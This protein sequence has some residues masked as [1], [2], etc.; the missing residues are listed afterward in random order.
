MFSPENLS[1]MA[2]SVGLT[3]PLTLTLK[4]LH[5]D[6]QFRLLVYIAIA[7]S[8]LSYALYLSLGYFNDIPRYFLYM[9]PIFLVICLTILYEIFSNRNITIGITLTLPMLLLLWI[10]SIL[11]I[12]KGGVYISYG[13]PRLNWTNIPLM[14]QLVFY[15]IFLLLAC[16]K[17]GV[18]LKINLPIRTHNRLYN[19]SINPQRASFLALIITI[20]AFSIHFSAYS[21]SNSYYFDENTAHI[22]G[23]L[24]QKLDLHNA[25]IFSNFYT[26]MRP[27]IPD[28]LLVENFLFPPPMIEKEFINFLRIAPN[29]TF[30]IISR[31]A[32]IAWYEYANS[33]IKKYFEIN[34]FPTDLK[35]I[36]LAMKAHE[37]RIYELSNSIQLHTGIRNKVGIESVKIC[38]TN[39]TNVRLTI[40]AYSD[41]PQK[42]FILIGT[43]RFSKI[44]VTELRPGMNELSW[45]FQYRLEN[46][47]GYGAYI[48]SMSRVLIYDESGN[49]LH[50][51]THAFR[52]AGSSLILWI[53]I[54]LVFISFMS[55]LIVRKSIFQRDFH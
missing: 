49:I 55:F 30:I 45:D 36:K 32:R 1:L 21:I 24:L 27:Y 40:K 54:L 38:M 6:I 22:A 37:V 47:S 26:Y 42:I 44:L 2:A 53:V 41:N 8:W 4:G 15:V 51:K 17:R 33:Y 46:R 18:I 31:D 50:D 3:L 7:V 52:L 16:S 48:A 29:N 5:G 35:N 13:L 12:E 25:L 9:T 11:S 28:H 34:A 23:T 39:A 14:S 19:V 10:Q 20:L 43:L